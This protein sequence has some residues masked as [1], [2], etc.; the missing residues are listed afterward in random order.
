MSAAVILYMESQRN[1]MPA[2][3]EEYNSFLDLYRKKLYHQLTIKLE[4]FVNNQHDHDL[5]LNLYQ[6]FIKDFETKMNQL[7]LVKISIKISNTFTD[8]KEAINFEKMIEDK[9]KG[10]VQ[11]HILATSSV[12]MLLLQ[13]GSIDQAKSTIE[14]AQKEIEG[15]AG[16]DAD[17][18]ASFYKVFAYLF[19]AQNQPIEFYNNSLKYLAYVQVDSIPKAE[20][21]ELAYD[22]CI[23]SLIGD[24]IYNFGELLSHEILKALEGGKAE[25]LIEMLR[26][27]NA[28]DIS[29]YSNLVSRYQNE[30]S[31]QAPL[32][33]NQGILTQKISILALMELAFKRPSDQRTISF[34][35]VADASKLSIHEVEH[36]IMKGLSLK[37]VKGTIDE[38]DKTVTITWV[39]PRV[40]DVKQIG[41][42]KDRLQQ[43]T[44][45]V[46]QTLLSMELD[47]QPEIFA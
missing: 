41:G 14:S 23:A 38:I 30:L 22:L 40:L 12:A 2:L 16:I 34:S 18:Y 20:Q 4:A 46:E 39:Q 21:E 37:L 25:W 11:A 9:V 32:T 24:N 27:F 47:V 44:N 26:V 8:K 45:K 5:L 36:L 17:V 13:S 28:G 7:S 35:S 43:W 29:G 15:V 33:A 31:Q 19:K 10:D 6:K 1:E 42:M 3:T